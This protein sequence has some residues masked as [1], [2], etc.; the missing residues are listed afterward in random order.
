MIEIKIQTK[1]NYEKTR[2]SSL[3]SIRYECTATL[4]ENIEHKTFK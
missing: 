1:R 2:S 3:N 4:N